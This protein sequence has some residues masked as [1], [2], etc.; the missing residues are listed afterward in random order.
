VF[1]SLYPRKVGKDG[2]R[3]K[4][5]QTKPPLEDVK[6]AL[7]WQV[8]HWTDQQ[9]IPYPATYLHNGRWKDERPKNGAHGRYEVP[10][11]G[12]GDYGPLGKQEI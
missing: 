7:A 2:A 10:A 8:K 9:F 12:E 11:P 1:W 3:R 6:A 5:D 4:W